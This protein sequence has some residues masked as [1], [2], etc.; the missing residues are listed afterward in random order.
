MIDIT[1]Q[2]D[3]YCASFMTCLEGGAR[4]KLADLALQCFMTFTL[5][6][7]LFYLLFTEYKKDFLENIF[8]GNTSLNI[9]R[10]LCCILLHIEVLP[11]I[12]SA[13]EMMSFAKK[14]PTAFVH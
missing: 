6:T 3:I 10:F 5:Q 8:Y 11:E 14:N 9:V 13:K 12:L 4:K 7:A 1:L 2:E